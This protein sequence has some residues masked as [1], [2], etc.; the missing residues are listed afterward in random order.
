VSTWD[1][2][3]TTTATRE[4]YQHVEADTYEEAVVKARAAKDWRR[5]DLLTSSTPLTAVRIKA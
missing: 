4:H 5:G 1:V 3:Y 2:G